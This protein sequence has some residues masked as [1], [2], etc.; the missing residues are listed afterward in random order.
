[1]NKTKYYNTTSVASL[2]RTGT[3]GESKYIDG[4]YGHKNSIT[5]TI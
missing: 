4:G 5:I 3:L 1:M 2:F